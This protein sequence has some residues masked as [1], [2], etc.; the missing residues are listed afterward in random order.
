MMFSSL[1]GWLR[2][3]L[4]MHVYSMRRNSYKDLSLFR[5]NTNRLDDC[6]V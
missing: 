3:I 4:A 5:M 2:L 6:N 1:L